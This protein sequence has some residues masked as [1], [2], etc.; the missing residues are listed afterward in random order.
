MTIKVLFTVIKMS[1]SNL[2]EDGILDNFTLKMQ[3]VVHQ[4]ASSTSVFC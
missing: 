4:A 1:F 2:D 3:K